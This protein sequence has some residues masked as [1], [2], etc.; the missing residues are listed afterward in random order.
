MAPSIN[1]IYRYLRK[2]PPSPHS[3]SP[4]S[5]G[6]RSNLL[7]RRLVMWR[8]YPDYIFGCRSVYQYITIKMCRKKKRIE[9]SIAGEWGGYK[10]NFSYRK[11][12]LFC[13]LFPF[14]STLL[15]AAFISKEKQNFHFAHNTHQTE[16]NTYNKTM[17][18]YRIITHIFG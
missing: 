9:E 17:L 4:C 1:N 12:F 3:L 11:L 18:L 10:K 13:F 6:T 14:R 8:S 2:Y 7:N 15:C 5:M 16:Y